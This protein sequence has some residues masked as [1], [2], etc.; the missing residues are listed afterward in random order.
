V[1]APAGFLAAL[2]ERA[3]RHGILL[4]VDEIQTGYGRT[5]RFWAHQH[6]APV[7]PDVLITAK[8]LASGFP[9][10][11]IAAPTGLMRRARPGSQGG[12]YGGNPVACAAALATL[13]VIRD[14]RLV[15]NAAEQGSRL[16]DGARTVAAGAAA[17]ADV[18]GLGLMV[19]NEFRHPDGSP[20]P[21]TA[22]YA[23]QAAA[24]A[25]LLLLTCGI[26]LNVV[27]MVPAL[28]VSAEQIDE[29]LAL[30]SKAVDL[31]TAATN[32]P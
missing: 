1:P 26:D 23:Q 17:L 27:R 14:E 32:R 11:A 5:G 13:D 31:A 9:L 16:L 28:V 6:H 24:D 29:A 25:G 2:R 12:T 18:R 7:V 8:G 20:D 19:G 15:A 3:D 30:W 22:R 21:D 4:V 10:S